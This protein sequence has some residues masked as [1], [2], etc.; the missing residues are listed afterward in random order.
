M[1]LKKVLWCI[2]FAVLCP[3]S[4]MALDD[5]PIFYDAWEEDGAGCQRS[6]IEAEWYIGFS[7]VEI[8]TAAVGTVKFLPLSCEDA[9]RGTDALDFE[10]KTL[11]QQGGFYD[12][13]VKFGDHK[14]HGI[15]GYKDLR[16]RVK[17]LNVTEEKLR[18]VIQ[19]KNFQNKPA[20]N[21]KIS[22]DAN[23]SEIIIPLTSFEGLVEDDTIYGAGFSWTYPDESSGS[24]L[25]LL[26]DDLRIT[27]GENRPITD[28]P[29]T[30]AGEVPSNWPD[31]IATGFFDNRMNP[32]T[33]GF[34]THCDYRYQ[35]V[36]PET[37][38]WSPNYVKDYVNKSD[39]LGYKSGIVWYNFG[40]VS[41]SEVARNLSNASFMN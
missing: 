8:T 39:E 2:A 6:G 12:V 32:A 20:K 23:W 35:Y 4:V 24:D 19:N 18:V 3:L 5:L 9:F 14:P 30:G 7:G 28:V 10:I 37:F 26:I 16:F 40:K 27:D 25:H 13:V 31:Y 1:V 11:V 38:G 22:A 17:N 21:V 29:S 36:M 15:A 41:E 33:S 34:N